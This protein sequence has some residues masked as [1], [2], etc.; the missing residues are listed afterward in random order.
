M[1]HNITA[2]FKSFAYAAEGIAYAVRNERN[3][4]FHLCAAVFVL[5]ASGFYEFSPGEYCVMFLCIGLVT[6]AE[7]INTAVEKAVDLQTDGKYDGRAKA[8]KDCSAGAVLI[9]SFFAAL[10][11]IKLFWDTEVFGKILAWFSERPFAVTAAVICLTAAFFFIFGNN[12]KKK[13]S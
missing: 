10:C 1:K 9:S 5:W 2:F 8:A 7:L 12:S 6:S 4:R 13:G 3:F 11:G